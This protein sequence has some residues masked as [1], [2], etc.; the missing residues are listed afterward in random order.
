MAAEQDE[1]PR[2]QLAITRFPPYRALTQTEVALRD[3]IR[4]NAQELEGLYGLLRGGRYHAL[5]LTT[6]EESVM[7]A[8]RDIAG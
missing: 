5:A 2:P 7:W 1:G 8:G 6:L 4:A 3:Q